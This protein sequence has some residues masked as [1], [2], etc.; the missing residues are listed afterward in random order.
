MAS[1]TESNDTVSDTVQEEATADQSEIVDDQS[2]K[3]LSESD[4]T[5]K[6][7]EFENGETKPNLNALRQKLASAKRVFSDR[8]KKSF[9]GDDDAKDQTTRL[10]HV[11]PGNNVQLNHAQ[12]A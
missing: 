3:T 11:W 7:P 4:T 6:K 1:R 12:T 10:Y 9:H 2:Q 8:L 5:A